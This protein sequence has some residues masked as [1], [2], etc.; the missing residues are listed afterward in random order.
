MQSPFVGTL[1]FAQIL[2]SFKRVPRKILVRLGT[3]TVDSGFVTPVGSYY[4]PY[5]MNQSINQSINP[6]PSCREGVRQL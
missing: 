3:R 1:L 4:K 5:Q 6:L 2:L